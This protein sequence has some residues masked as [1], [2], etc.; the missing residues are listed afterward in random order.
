MLDDD[1]VAPVANLYVISPVTQFGTTSH[2]FECFNPPGIAL[3][4]FEGGNGLA[5]VVALVE[6]LVG[7]SFLGSFLSR[8]TFCLSSHEVLAAELHYFSEALRALG[9]ALFELLDG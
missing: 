6:G 1:G 4:V 2:G 5:L 9:H 3:L 8:M 7:L